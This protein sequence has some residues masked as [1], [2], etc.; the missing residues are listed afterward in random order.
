M[1]DTLMAQRYYIH[2]AAELSHLGAI[3]DGI[4]DLEII[5]DFGILPENRSLY[6]RVGRDLH[7]TMAEVFGSNEAGNGYLSKGV[8]F[9]EN[10]MASLTPDSVGYKISQALVYYAHKNDAMCLAT[11][12]ELE[13]T[14]EADHPEYSLVLTIIGGRY[15]LRGNPELAQ[16]YLAR[17]ALIDLY[18]ADRQGSALVRLGRSLY[19]LGDIARAHN[20]LTVALDDALRAS[21]KT[22][23]IMVSEALMPVAQDIRDRNHRKF[24]LLTALVVCLVVAMVLLGR[25][26]HGKR[27]QVKEMARVRHA[28]ATA[29]KTKETYIAEFMNLCS[30]YME[31]LEDFNRMSKRKIAAG[32]S[33]DLMQLIKSGKVIEE[34][35]R[36]FYDI[37]DDSFLAIYPTF[38]DDVNALLYPDK[39]IVTPGPNVLSTGFVCLLSSASTSTT[40][41]R[42]PASSVCRST[43][44]TPI[45][46]SSATAPCRATLSS[47]M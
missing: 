42:L 18:N 8:E 5:S 45:A 41:R 40:R 33:D 29:N 7:L 21:A 32:Q 14:L 2:R 9:A 20:Y 25:L 13:G 35:R 34:Q 36:K 19:E 22:N 1:G 38:I 6:Y 44:S 12:H 39:R 26:Y 17:A 24:V 3:A 4:R 27:L 30:S 47:Q 10:H 46:T 11:L 15:L 28:L 43:L 37:F 31:S 23:C 16:R